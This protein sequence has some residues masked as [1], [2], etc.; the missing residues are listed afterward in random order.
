MRLYFTAAQHRASQTIPIK[1]HIPPTNFTRNIS[2]G[3]SWTIWVK[4]L[5]LVDTP[6]PET[7]NANQWARGLSTI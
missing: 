6:A 4:E 1:H 5:S 3:V 2:N 7:F